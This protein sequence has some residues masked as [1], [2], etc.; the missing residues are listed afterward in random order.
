MK[1]R[2]FT[3]IELMVILVIIAIVATVAL[4]S[5]TNI[6]R[7]NRLQAQQRQLL[8]AINLA[9]SEASH[10]NQNITIGAKNGTSWEDGFRIYTDNDLAGNTSYTAG[11]DTLIK[12]I[13][14]SNAPDLTIRSN[15]AGD[16]FISFQGNGMLN[17]GANSISIAICDSRGTS[18]GRGITISRVGRAAVS[19]N[20]ASCDP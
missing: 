16:N 10:R 3:L 18:E 2:G 12:D 4:P 20:I 19:T 5:Y 17:E 13:D 15:D 14:G 11:T 6:I 8:A 9:R 1:Q 7:D